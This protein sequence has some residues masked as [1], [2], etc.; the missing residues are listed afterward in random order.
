[1]RRAAKVDA[2]HRTIVAAFRAHGCTVQSLA[3]VGAGVP[4][5]LVAFNGRNHLVEVKDGR[6]VKS[7]RRL[8]EAQVAWQRMWRGDVHLVESVEDVTKLMAEWRFPNPFSSALL[9][10]LGEN[11]PGVVAVPGNR[12]TD[13]T[14]RRAAWASL[15]T[16]GATGGAD[17]SDYER[18]AK[19]EVRVTPNVIRRGGGL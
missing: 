4:D 10:R 12:A 16:M 17:A 2:N 7:E 3:A 13:D 18:P 1:M 14:A 8:T 9:N 11:E 6:R 15:Y 5:L 19:R